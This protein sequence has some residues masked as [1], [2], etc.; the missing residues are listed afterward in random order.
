MADVV[1]PVHD[2]HASDRPRLLAALA[3]VQ[4]GVVARWQ[5]VE[6]GWGR[7]AIAHA[8]KLGRLHRVHPGVYAVGHRRLSLR[9]HWMAAVLA[10]G[11]EALLSHVCAGAHWGLVARGRGGIDVTVPG[12]SRSGQPGIAIHL[13]RA[14]DHRDRTRKDGIPVTTVSRT[15]L[16][17]AEVLPGNRLERAVEEADRLHLLHAQELQR[18]LKRSPGRHGLKPLKVVLDAYR[19]PPDTRSELERRFLELVRG[20]GLP[21]PATNVHVVGFEVDAVWLDRK[22]V[23]ELDGFAYHRT[24][25]AFE[26]DRERDAALQL[27][28]YRAPRLTW[29]R[30]ETEPAQVID[31]LKRLLAA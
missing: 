8:L 5:L 11:P 4:H 14:L 16:D 3:R 26:R 1:D 7:G 23:V 20:A 13:V 27:A 17:L 12:R 21:P 10:C 15:I 28:G 9:G 22:V 2:S 19:L 18:V 24:R 29:R 30:I 25:D 6:M 31:T